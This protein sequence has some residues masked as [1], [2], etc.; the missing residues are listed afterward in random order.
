MILWDRLDDAGYCITAKIAEAEKQQDHKRVSR[1]L[2]HKS[3]VDKIK[4]KLFI[5]LRCAK[6][7]GR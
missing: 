5:V 7:S 2:I 3:N 4:T 1:L 6:G